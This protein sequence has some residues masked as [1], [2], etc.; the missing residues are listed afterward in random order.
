MKAPVWDDCCAR[1]SHAD[2]AAV[3]N[4]MLAKE[5]EPAFAQLAEK[6]LDSTLE[7]QFTKSGDCTPLKIT[8]YTCVAFYVAKCV[9]VIATS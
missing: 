3:N 6:K 1:A 5:S 4:R 9:A 8:R 2:E 7:C